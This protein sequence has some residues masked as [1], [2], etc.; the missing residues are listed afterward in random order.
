MALFHRCN[1]ISH[2]TELSVLMYVEAGYFV[3]R[4]NFA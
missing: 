4:D 1:Q 2:C 3:M